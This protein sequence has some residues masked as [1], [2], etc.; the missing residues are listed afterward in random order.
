MAQMHEDIAR[1][2]TGVTT[3]GCALPE[4]HHK[5]GSP[6]DHLVDQGLRV[7]TGDSDINIKR[8]VM[9]NTEMGAS[10]EQ[11]PKE[12]EPGL[13]M[14]AVTSITD[15]TR[16]GIGKGKLET[17]TNGARIEQNPRNEKPTAEETRGKGT[18]AR[19]QHTGFLGQNP[20]Y[21]YTP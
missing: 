7:W 5:S 6:I 15:L 13:A 17:V 2:I 18:T 9:P 14:M 4:T 10:L 8:G 19:I 11:R 21:L 20:M 3:E 16:L 12:I 1:D